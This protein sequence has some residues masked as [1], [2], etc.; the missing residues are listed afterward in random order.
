M[1][2]CY[3]RV[4]FSCA[5]VALSLQS[6]A[7][8]V[9]NFRQCPGEAK[10]AITDVS[11]T[12][13]PEAAEGRA[14]VVY[15]G[16]NVTISFDFTPAFSSNELTADVYWTQPAIDLPFIG[17]DPAACKYTACP[18]TKDTKQNYTYDLNIKK[19]Y[20][21]RQYDVKWKLVG[22]NAGDECCFILQINITKKKKRT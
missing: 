17:M 21:A 10:C 8:E 20:P 18:V 7:A 16:S 1:K 13:C 12:P 9:I 19:S 5:L 22:E 14:C 15:S 6:V 4:L 11:I 3:Y 2:S